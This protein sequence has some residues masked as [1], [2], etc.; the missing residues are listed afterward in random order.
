MAADITELKKSQQQIEQMNQTLED[1]ILERTAQLEAINNDLNGFA[2]TV[3]HDLR[4]PL[5]AMEGFSQ[6]LLEDNTS[7]LDPIGQKYAERIDQSADHMEQLIQ[8]ILQYSCISRAD[9]QKQPI[10]LNLVIAR[11]CKALLPTIETT[12]TRIVIEPDLPYVEGTTQIIEQALTNLITNAFKF[13]AA[14]GTTPQISIS[15]KITGNQ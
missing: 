1:R 13:V 14:P 3:S 7:A 9:I 15:A 6:A 11:V 4:A 12:Q 2:Y 5:R 10:D 8:D